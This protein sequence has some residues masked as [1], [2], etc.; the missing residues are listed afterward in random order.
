LLSFPLE[1]LDCVELEELD[2]S[3]NRLTSVQVE[4]KRLENMKILKLH[5]NPLEGL[6]NELFDL[7][8]LVRLHL[9][10]CGLERIPRSITRLSRSISFIELDLRGNNIPDIPENGDY[11]NKYELY[12]AFG[13]RVVSLDLILE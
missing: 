6:P 13:H 1:I 5:H 3:S 12:N 8:N 4:I 2:L 9:S 7:K 11:L 10:F